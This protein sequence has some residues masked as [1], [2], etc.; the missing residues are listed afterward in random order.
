MQ[1]TEE[2]HNMSVKEPTK[3]TLQSLGVFQKICFRFI[4]VG[5]LSNGTK[6]LDGEKVA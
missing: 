6:E 2:S 1:E 3:E 5:M 4:Y